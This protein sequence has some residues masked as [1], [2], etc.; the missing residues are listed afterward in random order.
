[1]QKSLK[2]KYGIIILAAGS[3]SRMGQPKQLLT[4]KNKSLIRHVSE[5][6]RKAAGSNVTVVLGS[7]AKDIEKELEDMDITIAENTEWQQGMASSIKRGLSAMSIADL[8]VVI[9]TV[10]DQPFVS[11][12]LFKELIELKENTGKGIVACKYDGTIG[13]PALFDRTY[14]Q[15]LLD[16][17][18]EEG[19]KKLLSRHS[20]DL[21]TIAFPEGKLDIDTMEDYSELILKD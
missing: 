13:T 1:M 18:G 6:A 7:G 19:A 17:D 12:D 2:D 8:D 20:T 14:F 21:T 3:S 11:S 15:E 4:Y 10:C 16:L 5:E 9:L